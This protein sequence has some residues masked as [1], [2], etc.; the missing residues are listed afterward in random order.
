M[1]KLIRVT[2][3]DISLDSLLEGQLHFLNEYF[4][5]IGLASDT[6]CLEK[7]GERTP[8]GI[9]MIRVIFKKNRVDLGY[10]YCRKLREKG[11]LISAK[12]VLSMCRCTGKSL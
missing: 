5:V 7:V 2:T 4:E 9:D 10:E 12:Y 3:A 6:G 11:Y 1:N 8:D